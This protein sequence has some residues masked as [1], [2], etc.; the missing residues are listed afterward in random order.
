[1]DGLN[2]AGSADAASLAAAREDARKLQGK[3][4]DMGNIVLAASE[5]IRLRLRELEDELR[6]S[7]HEGALAFLATQAF[8]AAHAADAAAAVLPLFPGTA[9]HL[10][11]LSER[12]VQ[13][14]AVA[15]TSRVVA[16]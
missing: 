3:A 12:C 7:A 13:A 15:S 4:K 9:S 6:A 14:A 8:C 2:A 10:A 11:E 16:A 1:M 5:H